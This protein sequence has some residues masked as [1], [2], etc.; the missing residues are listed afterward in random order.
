[1]VVLPLQ[2]H[3]KK[4]HISGY[5]VMYFNYNKTFKEFRHTGLWPGSESGLLL[6]CISMKNLSV[7][8]TTVEFPKVNFIVFNSVKHHLDVGS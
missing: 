2:E 3:G 7:S 6:F 8:H 4:I 1:M 5:R